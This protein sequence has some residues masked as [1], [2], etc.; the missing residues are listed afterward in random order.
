MGLKCTIYK[1][2]IRE[3]QKLSQCPNCLI[4]FHEEH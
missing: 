2:E 3:G 1:L 4:V